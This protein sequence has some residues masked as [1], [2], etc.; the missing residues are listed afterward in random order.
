ML[1]DMT[2]FRLAGNVYFV[3]TSKQSSHL[4]DTGDGLIL[5]DIG[6]EPNASVVM[7]SME[8]LG[9]QVSDVKYIL[10]SHG[11]GDHSDGVPKIVAASG[12][13]VYM[14]EQDNQRLLPRQYLLWLLLSTSPNMYC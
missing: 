13:T 9:F 4:I 3:G 12:A 2:P 1:S 11:H 10:L 7:E 5:L 14:F 8:T 6:D